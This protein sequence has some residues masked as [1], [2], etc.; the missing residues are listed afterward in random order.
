MGKL[1]RYL[2]RLVLLLA[3]AY[4]G[5]VGA[6]AW[7]NVVA[8]YPMEYRENAA[9]FT[10]ALQLEGKNQY[11]LEQRPVHVNL[12][13]GGYYWITYP[14]VR[15]FG[16][17]YQTLRA[18]SVAFVLASCG[19]VIWGLRLDRCPWWAAICGGALLL[20]QLGQGLSVTAR[21][22]GFGLFL[23]L[24][25][26]VI[27][28][29][30]QFSPGS[31]A[32]GGA[33]AILG[34]LTK[35]YCI[36]G[37]P[38][39]SL[40]VFLFKDKLKGFLFGLAGA[41]ALLLSLVAMNAVYECYL[42]ETIVAQHNIVQRSFEHLL[43][44]GGQF[45]GNNWGLCAILAG[46]VF[47]WIR[48]CQNV[49]PQASATAGAGF[50]T[51]SG[52]LLPFEVPFPAVI[53]A[54]NA[55]VMVLAL[56]LNPGNDVLYYHQLISP[57][58]LWLVMLLVVSR[59]GFWQ[60]ARLL[61]LLANIVWLG[62]QRPAWP[63]DQSAAWR[64]LE[65]LI[66]LH[67]RVFT[68]AHLS[69]LLWR[70][71]LPVYDSGQTEYSLVAFRQNPARVAGS[72]LQRTH[73]FL[74]DIQNKLVNEDF[75]LVLVCRGYAPFFQWDNLKAHYVFQGELPAPMAFGYWIAPYPVE[76]WVPASAQRA[77]PGDTNTPAAET[78]V[79]PR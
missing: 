10:S 61:V 34:Y 63:N 44:V 5:Y 30:S 4:G 39:L 65:R 35:P 68:S 67:Q 47:P 37:L 42:T 26:L 14:V 59:T 56:G 8:D 27:P 53:L 21:P 48:A 52:P 32:L 28:Y 75:E 24:A 18:V 50:R 71:G 1:T 77:V 43:R 69:H 38:L 3:L 62:V 29:R 51:L 33:L 12:F 45:L 13:G 78:Q 25:S 60:Q 36:L 66:T 73:A 31:L 46:G 79:L 9:L 54:C 15:W 6:W 2:S 57:F 74:Q 55:A 23:L 40:H 17:S 41:L 49:I 76:M 70:H 72:Y 11:S 19:M 58:L 7:R 16:N 20:G 64:N 22:D